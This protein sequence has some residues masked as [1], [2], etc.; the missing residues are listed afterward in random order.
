MINQKKISINVVWT[1]LGS[2]MNVG[3]PAEKD[4]YDV[5]TTLLSSEV[6]RRQTILPAT[7]NTPQP[8]SQ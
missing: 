7:A 4:V 8:T 6:K 5:D 3:S 1:N 2:S